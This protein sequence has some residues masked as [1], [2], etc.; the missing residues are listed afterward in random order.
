[1]VNVSTLKLGKHAPVYDR[2]APRFVNYAAALAPP[3]AALDFSGPVT[4]LGM[5]LN[6]SLGDCTCA[7]VGHMI[8][9]WT[10]NTGSQVILPDADIE[11]LY[12]KACGYVPGNPNTDQGGNEISVLSYWRDSGIFPGH[13][14]AGWCNVSP[15]NHTQVMQ[16]LQLFGAVYLGVDLPLSAQSQV[17]SVWDVPAGGAVG[18]GAPGSWGGHAVPIVAYDAEGITVITWGAYQ[19]ATWAFV[20]AYVDEAHGPLAANWINRAGKSPDG[21]YWT[22]L[23]ADLAVL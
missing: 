23:K 5:M 19:K 2:T 12:E 4:N 11:T 6:D 10:A 7:A 22:K 21:F 15:Q 3:P 8:Q 18:N 9:V 17:G 13:T 20:D 1:M 16:A 14:L